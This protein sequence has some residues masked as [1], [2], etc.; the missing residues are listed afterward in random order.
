MTSVKSSCIAAICCPYS[1]HIDIISELKRQ[2]SG[3]L[4]G[5]P[6][7]GFLSYARGVPL[8]VA[9]SMTP[10]SLLW[11]EVLNSQGCGGRCKAAKGLVGG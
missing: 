10:D 9:R 11:R 3:S 4:C 1:P 6:L 8:L 2:Y 5:H 7:P